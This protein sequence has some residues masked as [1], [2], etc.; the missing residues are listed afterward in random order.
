MERIK[1][2]ILLILFS[3]TLVLEV[4]GNPEKVEA[5]F[6]ASADTYADQVHPDKSYGASEFLRVRSLGSENARTYIFFDISTIPPGA[7]VL[8][9]KL[10]LYLSEPPT[11]NRTYL[12]YALD[13]AWDENSLTWNKKP[14]VRSIYVASSTV[15]TTP[16]WVIWDVTDQIQMF[17]NGIEEYAWSNFGFEI[18]DKFEDSSEPQ[19]AAFCAR[20]F[21]ERNKRPFLN[22]E[23]IPPKL[24]LTV[25][26]PSLL[27]GEWIGLIIKRLAQDGIVVIR[28]DRSVKQDWISFGSTTIRLSTSSRTGVFSLSP[29]GEPVDEVEI[30]NGETQIIVYYSDTSVGDY[31]LSAAAKGYPSGYY[32]EGSAQIKVIV[33]AYPPQIVNVIRS[34]DSPVMGEVIKVSALITDVGS[35]VKEAVLYY[36]TDGGASWSKVVMSLLAGRYDA[37]IPGQNAFT[38]ISY[39][40]EASDKSG[41]ITKTEV[42]KISVGAPVWMY[43]VIVMLIIMLLIG[44]LY[45][46]RRKG[47]KTNSW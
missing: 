23:F 8:R 24:N 11:S 7:T 32:S 1:L 6:Q 12:C 3:T 30:R 9:A 27:S 16:G 28:A 25:S 29:G 21:T 47:R 2:C 17:L 31:T 41:N 42:T 10:F 40:V 20:E 15:T 22:V 39:Y 43:V 13:S 14:R 18:F 36:S 5:V 45:I 46:K 37:Y 34:P 19:E 44:F 26:S 4:W 33:D 35:G 38:E